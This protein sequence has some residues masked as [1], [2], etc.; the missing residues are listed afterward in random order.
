MGFWMHT[1]FCHPHADEAGMH[2]RVAS[3][4]SECVDHRR[5]R[6]RT[7]EHVVSPCGRRLG[8]FAF[9]AEHQTTPA[10]GRPQR[11]PRTPRHH[12]GSVFRRAPCG[13]LYAVK[14][15]QGAS[16]A[17][18]SSDYGF[19]RVSA[20]LPYPAAV[21]A[22]SCQLPP[23]PPPNL[24]CACTPLLQALSPTSMNHSAPAALLGCLLALSLALQALA[25]PQGTV[26]AASAT[27][28]AQARAVDMGGQLTIK[29]LQLQ[30]EAAPSTLLLKRFSVSISPW[31]CL[32]PAGAGLSPCVCAMERLSARH[33]AC[34]CGARAPLWCSRLRWTRRRCSLPSLA[35]PTLLA[36]LK[37]PLARPCCWPFAQTAPCTAQPSW[38]PKLGRWARHRRQL[39]PRQPPSGAAGARS[40]HGWWA[41][42]RPAA[43]GILNAATILAT[44]QIWAGAWAPARL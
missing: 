3:R 12:L 34:R 41:P 30:A 5:C 25:A 38:A 24:A 4:P 19:E 31:Y 23:P 8:Q 42:T 2:K 18:S 44:W 35:P 27:F 20:G 22:R 9:I 11:G 15:R 14:V 43:R 13:L 39:R 17:G 16:E 21:L 1:R 7:G 40:L 26:A 10:R 6:R 29:G 36:S 33:P 37:T 28:V 32:L